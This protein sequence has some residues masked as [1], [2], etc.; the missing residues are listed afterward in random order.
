[1]FYLNIIFLFFGFFHKQ[2]PKISIFLKLLVTLGLFILPNFLI[3]AHNGYADMLISFYIM[4]SL[5]YFIE[6]VGSKNLFNKIVS[7]ELVVMNSAATMLIKNEGYVFFAIVLF[8]GSFTLWKFFKN[9]KNY[10]NKSIIKRIISIFLFLILMFLIAYKWQEFLKFKN[11]QSTFKGAYI[12]FDWK[13]R[14][15][16]ILNYYIL[17][18]LNTSRYSLALIIMT[19]IAIYEY[20]FI[21]VKKQFKILL[22]SLILLMQLISYIIVYLITPHSLVWQIGSSIDRLTL[23]FLPAFFII[24][25]YQAFV[26]KYEKK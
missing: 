6:M 26:L 15:K 23:H 2:L 16:S 24:V 8:I 5:I 3:Y 9:N 25:I 7:F 1:L 22:P 11:I 20:L 12:P 13:F 4:I 21:F 14:L 19:I 17:E 10:L 18:F